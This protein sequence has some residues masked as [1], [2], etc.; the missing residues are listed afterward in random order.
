MQQFSWNNPMLSNLKLRGLWRRIRSN[1][2]IRS[3]KMAI[4]THQ[5][6]YVRIGG[7]G[8]AMGIAAAVA[9]Y[10]VDNSYRITGFSKDEAKAQIAAL[11][12]QNAALQ[13]TADSLKSALND[14]ESQLKVEKSAQ[15]ELVKN[16]SQV[17][18]ENASLKEDLGFLRNI[19]SAG[20]V[21]DGLSITNL[22]VES[23]AQTAE[24]R[25]RMLLTQGGQ[26]RADF[27]G[28][29]Q[30][31]VRALKNS[32]T[33]NLTFPEDTKNPGNNGEVDFK[34]Y[35]KV[36]GR[37]KLPEGAQLKSVQVRVLGQQ[38]NEVRATKAITF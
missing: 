3:S 30:L 22:K 31:V 9:W 26:R 25:Y 38:G 20:K 6:W 18:E 14:R 29:V 24:I 10:L 12:E 27:K 17:Q 35:Q 33:L 4:K 1:I 34:Y 21:P 13:K 23:D 2:G 19:M 37:F 7:F 28:R 16:S 8:L 5:P 11:A 15:A 32:E 36:E